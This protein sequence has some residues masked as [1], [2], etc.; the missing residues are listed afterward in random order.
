MTNASGFAIGVPKKILLIMVV[1]L[2]CPR[3]ADIII[4]TNKTIGQILDT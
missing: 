2:K 4:E 3:F 1:Y